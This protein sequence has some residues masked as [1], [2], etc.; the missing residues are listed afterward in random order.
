MIAKQEQDGQKKRCHKPKVF[1]EGQT[2]VIRL[3]LRS[4][5]DAENLTQVLRK[6]S[7]TRA[8]NSF[9]TDV[10]SSPEALNAER[11]RAGLLQPQVPSSLIADLA[12]LAAKVGVD[13]TKLLR[14]A[15][16]VDRLSR[17]RQA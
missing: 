12:S 15:R 10:C 11:N 16:H 9:I 1:R 17:R 7:G 6:E 4:D 13:R 8:L 2:V 14:Q 3:T 5:N